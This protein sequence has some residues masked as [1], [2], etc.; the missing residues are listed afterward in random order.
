MRHQPDSEPGGFRGQGW[1]GGKH[2]PS[3]IAHATGCNLM[4]LFASKRKA[5]ET[6]AIKVLTYL[7]ELCVIDL[8]G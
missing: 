5:L 2:P 3:I 1:W 7:M 8:F 6:L 4:L